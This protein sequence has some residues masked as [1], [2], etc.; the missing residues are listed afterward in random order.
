MTIQLLESDNRAVG[1]LRTQSRGDLAV[2]A[3][4]QGGIRGSF[5]LVAIYP[6]C[7]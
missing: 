3:N 5:G 4:S 7:C 6:L 1:D 2:A